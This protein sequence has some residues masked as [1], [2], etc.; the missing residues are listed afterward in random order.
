MEMGARAGMEGDTHKVE[1]RKRRKKG[2]E[3]VKIIGKK[4]ENRNGN[5]KKK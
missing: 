4:I 1:E 2:E 5:R 3:K